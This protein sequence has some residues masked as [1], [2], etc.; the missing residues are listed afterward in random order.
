MKT[1]ELI[2]RLQQEDPS[3]EEEVCVDNIDIFFVSR[4]PAYYDGSSQVL[5]RD[6]TNPFYNIIGAKYKREGVKIQ[7]HLHSIHDAISENYNLPI[8]YSE[9]SEEKAN[10]VRKA[11]EE[12]RTW[13]TNLDTELERN[14]FVSWAKDRATKLTEDIEDIKNLAEL[15]FEKQSLTRQSPLPTGGVPLGESYYSTRH[16]QWDEQFEVVLVDGF[17]KIRNRER[18]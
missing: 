14:C 4:E 15:F 11:H 16:M 5:I 3:G 18:Q 1:K 9:L 6:E 12:Y 17:L 7:I 8:D 10:A 13:L 2:R